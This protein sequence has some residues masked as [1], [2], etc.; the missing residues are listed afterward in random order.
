M[1]GHYYDIIWSYIN[2]LTQINSREE[3]PKDGMSQDLIY[4][5]A[6]SLGL[7]MY[8]GNSTKDL[9]KYALGVDD[10]GDY[11]QTGSIQSLSSE[12]ST[13]EVWRRLVNNLPYILKSKGTSRSIKALLSCFGIPSTILTIKE[14]GGPSTFT[15]EDHFPE[16]EHD[17]FYYAWQATN[18]NTNLYIP[19]QSYANIFINT[20]RLNNE[21]IK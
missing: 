5:V 4:Y 19:S 21:I 15:V 11:I 18:S 8:N 9:W 20:S 14:Y 12:Q 17:V 6:K 3:H 16:Y 2:Q 10:N 7:N 1:I 13:K